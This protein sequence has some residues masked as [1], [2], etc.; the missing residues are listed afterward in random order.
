MS[1]CEG[2]AL[3]RHLVSCPPCA[4]RAESARG[5][6][7]L[8][9]SRLDRTPAPAKLRARLNDASANDWRELIATPKYPAFA[10]AAALLLL[11]LPIA[12]DVSP[13]SGNLSTAGILGGSAAAA[14]VSRLVPR[15]MTGVF[16]CLDCEAR[17]E[18]G[19]CPVSHA[20]HQEGFCADNGELWRLMP[21]HR[22]PDAFE[23]SVGRSAT[24]EGVAFPG[25]GFIRVSRVGY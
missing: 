2:D 11:L 18:A 13:G 15:Q 8:L 3:A 9:H 10:T 6:A 1:S 22:N 23:A 21:Q 19:L 20:D 12:S 17:S 25:S 24:V 14:S 7:R 4:A 5:L 16:V